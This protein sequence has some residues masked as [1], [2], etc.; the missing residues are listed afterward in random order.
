MA[1]LT[2]EIAVD[3]A[4]L[5]AAQAKLKGLATGSGG[6]GGRGG[7]ADVVI[8]GLSSEEK[9]KAEASKEQRAMEE[10]FSHRNA[11]IGV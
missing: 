8:P 1:K 4:Q 5:T 9:I 6:R 10:A 11:L 2:I 7:A 3:Q